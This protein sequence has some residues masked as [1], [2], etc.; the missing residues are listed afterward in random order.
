MK[1]SE[2]L[3]KA[4]D[5]IE[6]RGWTTGTKGMLVEGGG[7]CLEGAIQAARGGKT[8]ISMLHGAS[9]YK[10]FQFDPC[11]AGDAVRDYLGGTAFL[12]NDALERTEG[13]VI[14]VLRATALI[15]QVREGAPL[16]VLENA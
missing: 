6:E 10:T 14:E 8:W 2:V 3:N 7:L 11:P 15:E 1:T 12:W 16:S 9:A 13:E 4:A 5:L